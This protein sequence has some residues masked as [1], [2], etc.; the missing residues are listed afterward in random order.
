MLNWLISF[1]AAILFIIFMLLMMTSQSIALAFCVFVF[2]VSLA[3]FFH[4]VIDYYETCAKYDKQ[5]K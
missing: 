1:F 5:N 3:I 2:V 4:T